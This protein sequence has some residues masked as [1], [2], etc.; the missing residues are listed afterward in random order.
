MLRR[1]YILLTLSLF[2]FACDKTEIADRDKQD[3][4]NSGWLVDTTKMTGTSVVDV[5][6][7]VIE[8]VYTP[9]GEAPD[10]LLSDRAVVFMIDETVFIYPFWMMGV[11]VV[12][13]KI[14]NTYF[15]V[16]YCPK[17]R[18]T[19]VINRDIEG[20]IHT[21]RASGLLYQDN[22]VYYDLETG[23]FWSQ[24]LFKSIKGAHSGLEPAYINSF[25]T[26]Y[27]LAKEFFPEAIVF[28]DYVGRVGNKPI[29]GF[30]T[31]SSPASNNLVLGLPHH[32]IKPGSLPVVNF[33]HLSEGGL[34]KSENNMIVY[35]KPHYYINA[36]ISIPGVEFEFKNDFPSILTDNEGN[37]WDAF[38]H[39]ISG[40]RE[41]ERLNGTVSYLALWWAWEG[42]FK[43]FD[44]IF[45]ASNL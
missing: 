9:A 6:P 3:N 41:G 42:I 30:G 13:D 39:A 43:D 1:K 8:P 25:E 45:F 38:G 4:G 29:P 26:T 27:G 12:N 16:T 36:F 7:L 37:T 40:P 2:L 24:M 34:I 32:N 5:F 18:T 10:K 21:F 35:S 14:G 11:E 33:S 44:F 28:T 15:S 23:S 22:L 19:Y 17:T 31:K 20:S